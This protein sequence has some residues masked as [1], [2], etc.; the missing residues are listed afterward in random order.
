MRKY[1]GETIPEN[2]SEKIKVSKIHFLIHPGF[3]EAIGRKDKDAEALSR[4]QLESYVAE[5]RKLAANELIFAFTIDHRANITRH[6]KEHRA[7]IGYLRTLKSILGPRLILLTE[8]QDLFNADRAKAFT[9]AKRIA[10]SRGFT[11]DQNV[12][13]EGYGE[14]LGAC[15]D[16]GSISLNKQG[17]LNNPTIIRTSLTNNPRPASSQLARYEAK[18]KKSWPDDSDRIKYNLKH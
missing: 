6:A 17:N 1:H 13:S 12:F 9:A 14:T 7:Y 4:D 18:K 11:F 3:I 10:E 2:E 16:D 8:D 15:V 5:A